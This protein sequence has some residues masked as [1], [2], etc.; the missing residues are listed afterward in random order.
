MVLSHGVFVAFVVV[1][2]VVSTLLSVFWWWVTALTLTEFCV[3]V[4]FFQQGH[5]Q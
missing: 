4:R 3:F 5:V 1:V 2:V